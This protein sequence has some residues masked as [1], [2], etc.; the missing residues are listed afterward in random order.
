MVGRVG[1][2]PRWSDP[3]TTALS[4]VACSDLMGGPQEEALGLSWL[5]LMNTQWDVAE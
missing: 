2:G 4:S 1:P 5:K 3:K